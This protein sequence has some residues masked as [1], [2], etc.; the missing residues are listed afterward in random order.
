MVDNFIFFTSLLPPRFIFDAEM[1]VDPE[2]RDEA[3]ESVKEAISSGWT[4]SGC[5]T[6]KELLDFDLE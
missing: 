2:V 3:T 1:T 5:W 4:A 6:M